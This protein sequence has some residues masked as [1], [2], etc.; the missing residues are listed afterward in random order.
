MLIAATALLHK[1]PLAA[2]N[3][4]DFEG[5]GLTVVNPFHD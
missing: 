2:R 5:C 1:L 4:S 3:T